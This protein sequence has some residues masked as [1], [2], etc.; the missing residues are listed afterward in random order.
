MERIRTVK[1]LENALTAFYKEVKGQSMGE[2]AHGIAHARN[3][4]RGARP[5]GLLLDAS[6]KAIQ[7]ATVSGYLHDFKRTDSE[8][9]AHKDEEASAS[10]ANDFLTRLNDLGG[11]RTTH[12]QR[13]AVVYS[14]TNHGE[15]PDYWADPATRN[16]PITNL[17]D[18]VRVLNFAP[19]KGDANGAQV[20]ARRSMH[21]AGGR[22]LGPKA[23]LPAF[24]F[25]PNSPEDQMAAVVVEG[26][27]RLS[28]INPKGI[29]PDALSP[30]V[31]PLYDVQLP[32][33][34]GL[35]RAANLSVEEI[36]KLILERRNTQGI[37]M[38]DQRKLSAPR[39]VAG[40][41]KLFTEVGGLN[42]DAIHDAS[43]E[44]VTSSVRTLKYFQPRWN[45]D[46][47]ATVADWKPESPF[48]I[49]WKSDML[50]YNNGKWFN[51]I[52]RQ[53]RQLKND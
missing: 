12:E 11:F 29:Y 32:F 53:A 19:D 33:V 46:F 2:G 49:S 3:T 52:A 9:P 25:N 38:L 28:I 41:T 21:V 48:E 36:A 51:T 44:L 40:L 17:A 34:D 5:V 6:P 26:A 22:L 16:N 27:I 45:Q 8:D 42:D 43:P 13:Q 20:I 18:Q 10:I 50:D 47:D 24:G 14:I 30:F 4:G 15:Y 31:D 37:N 7:L 1:G 35:C 23:D 39:D